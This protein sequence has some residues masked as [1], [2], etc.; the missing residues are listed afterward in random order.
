MCI[1]IFISLSVLSCVYI[2]YTHTLPSRGTMMIIRNQIS[3]VDTQI[4]PFS[5]PSIFFL[6][7]DCTTEQS[8]KGKQTLSETQWEF[9]VSACPI[10]GGCL[11]KLWK[12]LFTENNSYLSGHDYQNKGFIVEVIR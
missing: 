7:Y 5:R 10:H 4:K 2:L 3:L 1:Y 6:M 11:K 12:L 9:M 8:E